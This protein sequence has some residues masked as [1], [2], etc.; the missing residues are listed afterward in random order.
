M[1]KWTCV[2]FGQNVK[3]S[4]LLPLQQKYTVRYPTRLSS[5]RSKPKIYRT[6]LPWPT[7]ICSLTS[8]ST[9]LELRPPPEI[10]EKWLPQWTHTLLNWFKILMSTIYPTEG[11][12]SQS[13]MLH[14]ILFPYQILFSTWASGSLKN[15]SKARELTQLHDEQWVVSSVA[16]SLK[17]Y[18][19]LW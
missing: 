11:E 12:I 8:S 14:D 18:L 15:N 19:S 7:V 9:P 3:K 6:F 17:K 5:H 4:F 10:P 13:C 1:K 2:I 16:F